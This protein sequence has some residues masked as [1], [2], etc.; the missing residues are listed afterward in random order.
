MW[1]VCT[2]FDHLGHVNKGQWQ[3]LNQHS[4]WK[5]RQLS[6]FP[7]L[8][9]WFWMESKATLWRVSEILCCF[10]FSFSVGLAKHWI[11][12]SMM[13][14]ASFN[15]KNKINPQH[16]G[17]SESKICFVPEFKLNARSWMQSYSNSDTNSDSCFFVLCSYFAVFDVFLFLFLSLSLNR[18]LR[19]WVEGWCCEGGVK[20]A[21]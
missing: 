8:D 4:N 3:S 13:I 1:C 7:D 11:P 10:I 19:F 21:G 5:N 12:L 2:L 16:Y 17:P 9:L 14:L 18:G 15:H 6:N 20:N